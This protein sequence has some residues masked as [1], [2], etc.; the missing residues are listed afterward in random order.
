VPGVDQVSLVAACQ[1]DAQPSRAGHVRGVIGTKA[2]LERK[3]G[4]LL[5]E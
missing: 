4:D 2:S 5:A 3:L 1:Y